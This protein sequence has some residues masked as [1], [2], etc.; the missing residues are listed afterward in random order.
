MQLGNAQQFASPGEALEHFGIKGMRWGFRKK[1]ETKFETEKSDYQKAFEQW[2]EPYSS[3]KSFGHGLKDLELKNPQDLRVDYSSG[4]ADVCSS[5]AYASERAVQNHKDLL[6]T[7]NDLRAEFP[8]VANAKIE[9]VPMSH[10]PIAKSLMRSGSPAAVV[11]VK[12]G[13]IR[14]TYND[15]LPNLTP[16]KQ[17]SWEKWVPGMGH[18]GYVGEH[19]G[20]HVLAAAYGAVKPTYDIFAE[21]NF[22]RQLDAVSAHQAAE[23]EAHGALFKKH[24]LAYSDV[25]KLSNYAATSH[26]EG[27]AEMVGNYRT[28]ALRAKMSP[29]MQRKAKAIIDEMGGK[30]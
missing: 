21:K 1:P 11:Q 5:R 3:S 2:G 7:V 10:Y 15:N 18:P 19:E 23:H 20:G 27:L 28:P 12:P 8:S 13:E 14:I 25:A 22:Y 17:A 24:G 29:D 16:K 4:F 9:V 26:A 6:K 30:K